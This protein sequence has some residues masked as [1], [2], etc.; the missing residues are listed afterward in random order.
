MGLGRR[1][2]E[3]GQAQIINPVRVPQGGGGRFGHLG[4][5]D[6]RSGGFN[7]HGR[8]RLGRR[9]S[10]PSGCADGSG[11]GG[12]FQAQC[13]E[14]VV[15]GQRG[16]G[17]LGLG[18]RRAGLGLRLGRLRIF[19][20]RHDLG[21]RQGLPGRGAEDGG[22]ES[23]L[24]AQGVEH[25]VVA[26]GGCGRGLARSAGRLEGLSRRGKEHSQ[27]QIINPVH[28]PQGGGG[29]LGRLGRRDWRG[30][31]FNRHGRHRLGRRR[32]FPSGCADGSGHGGAFQAQC[33]EHVVI[34][35][36]G[37]G[38]LGL[39][40][41]R[42]GLGL[43]LGRLRIFLSRHDL[44][45]RQGLPGRG[46]EDGGQ[47]SMLQAQGVEHV[48]V[49]H[50]GSGRGPRQAGLNCGRRRPR[51]TLDRRRRQH[52]PGGRAEGGRQKSAVQPHRF[53][54]LGQPTAGEEP[55]RG[56]TG[57]GLRRAGHRLGG[58]GHRGRLLH[59]G[60]GLRQ[61]CPVGRTKGDGGQG[62]ARVHGLQQ[63]VAA[64]DWARGQEE[65]FEHIAIVVAR[66]RLL[67]L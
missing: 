3:H 48:V 34:G 15:I 53:D 41:R 47:E 22:Q 13:A 18:R 58:G 52:G 23:V 65:Q 28:V 24:Q 27:A 33:A 59:R 50:G 36:R 1:D 30:G 61:G 51:C 63:V 66:H 54:L 56:R 12:A 60:F 42:A 9:R 6:W 67:H 5:R 4:R 46:A 7:R 31:S 8:H 10:F 37:G 57:H 19:L 14:H 45:R 25:V 21:R 32:S 55:G 38:R 2:E 17:R 20:S 62:V 35:Q 26:H 39:G 29:R 49:A 44:G 43:R 40:R 16:G 11:H 64:G